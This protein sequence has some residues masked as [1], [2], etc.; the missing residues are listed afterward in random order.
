M[1]LIMHGPQSN[2]NYK[3]EGYPKSQ[4]IPQILGEINDI[5]LLTMKIEKI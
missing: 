2:E 4:N 1:P 5:L 3:L